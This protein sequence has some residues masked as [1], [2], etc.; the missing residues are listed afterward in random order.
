MRPTVWTWASLKLGASQHRDAG[1]SSAAPSCRFVQ[2]RL[3]VDRKIAHQAFLG[4]IPLTC[5]GARSNSSRPTLYGS[6]GIAIVGCSGGAMRLPFAGP[7]GSATSPAN[8]SAPEKEAQP[9]PYRTN[10]DLPDSVARHLPPHRTSTGPLSIMPSRPMPETRVRK[11]QPPGS[12]APP[13]S[14]PT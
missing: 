3:G 1:N 10:E 11:K 7:N 13:S 4:S 2:R 5:S 14:A 6:A 8:S 9:M 12:H